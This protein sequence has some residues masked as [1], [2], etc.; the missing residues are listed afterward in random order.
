IHRVVGVPA[1]GRAAPRRYEASL[2]Q[3]AQ[4][5]RDQVLGLTDQAGQLVHHAVA[6]GELTQEAPTQGMPGQ[7]Q[8]LRRGDIRMDRLLT[9]T[10]AIYINRVRYV[11]PIW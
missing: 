7:L 5:V 4:V 2:P 1:I 9:H 10:Q 6:P 11:K 8:E 3:L